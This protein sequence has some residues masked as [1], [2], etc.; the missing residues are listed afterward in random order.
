MPSRDRRTLLRYLRPIALVLLVIFTALPDAG[1]SQER[2]IRVELK[3]DAHLS[4]HLTLR[5]G[6]ATTV[7]ISRN[8]LP[9]EAG[10]SLIVVTA[11]R[12]GQCLKRFV[13]VNDPFFDEVAVDP[14]TPLGG[15]VDLEA[16]FPDLRRVSKVS[17][18]QLFWAY[19]APAALQISHW[20]G[21]WILIPQQ[22]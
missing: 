7:K 18:V 20:S 4:L 5:S 1:D 13:P 21:G 15:D 9:W 2:G 16:L 6:A 17:D 10:N 14:N 8:N 12:N 22:K 3:R 11:I 19:E